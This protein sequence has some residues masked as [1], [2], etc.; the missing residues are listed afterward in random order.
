MGQGTAWGDTSVPGM[1]QML[2]DVQT[3]EPSEQPNG[4]FEFGYAE[5]IVAA[6]I[7]KKAADNH[8][9]T[10]AGLLYAFDSLGTVNM[11]GLLPDAHYGSAPNQRVPTRDSSVYALDPTQPGAVKNL[12]GDFVGTAAMAS[13][14]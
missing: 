13:Q 6:A 14:F 10:R 9:L 5:A 11:M 3:Y 1:A 12:S 4:Y 7:L 2:Q 8:D